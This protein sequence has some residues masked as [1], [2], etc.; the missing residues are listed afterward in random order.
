MASAATSFRVEH[1]GPTGFATREAAL[2]RVLQ[3]QVIVAD[4]KKLSL[5][6]YE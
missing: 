3:N 6:V 5:T 1:K 2:G 4:D